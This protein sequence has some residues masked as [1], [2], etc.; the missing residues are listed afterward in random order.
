MRRAFSLGL[1]LGALCGLLNAC[2]NQWLESKWESFQTQVQA[3]LQHPPIQNLNQIPPRNLK[4]FE[5]LAEPKLQI[6]EQISSKDKFGHQRLQLYIQTSDTP[7]ASLLRGI[8]S[9]YD[10][11]YDVVWIY[12]ANSEPRFRAKKWQAQ[13]AWFAP[14]IPE[15]EHFPGFKPQHQQEGFYWTDG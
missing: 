5:A 1:C 6:L 13:A 15:S 10:R 4:T 14:Q 3:Q 2:Q 11:R 8:V 9:R 7:T 12:L